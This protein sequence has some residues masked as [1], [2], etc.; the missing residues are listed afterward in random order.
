MFKKWMITLICYIIHTVHII[1]TNESR[2]KNF[3]RFHTKHRL[4]TIFI[5]ILPTHAPQMSK[6]LSK[7]RMTHL[8][9][10]DK[11]NQFAIDPNSDPWI[12]QQQSDDWSQLWSMDWST[13]VDQ[14]TDQAIT[15]TDYVILP[16][17]WY[18]RQQ[19][20][21]CQYIRSQRYVVSLPWNT[22][23]TYDIKFGYN[24]ASFITEV[25]C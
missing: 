16:K 4:Y 14:I 25:A 8:T 5:S 22:N 20:K 3:R 6:W 24:W 21:K 19:N 12:G 23:L 1:A 15:G 13:T 18:H 9:T 11:R 7:P 17:W 2:P 10:T